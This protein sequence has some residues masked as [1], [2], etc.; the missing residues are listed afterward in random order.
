MRYSDEKKARILKE[1]REGTDPVSAVAG[2]NGVAAS[3][4]VRWDAQAV[5]SEG[6]ARADESP[7]AR[8]SRELAELLQRL[9]R[10]ERLGETERLVA[11]HNQHVSFTSRIVEWLA[12]AL[13]FFIGL[14]VSLLWWEFYTLRRPVSSYIISFMLALLLF[15]LLF[16]I[17]QSLV[18]RLRGFKG[19]GFVSAIVELFSAEEILAQDTTG[20]LLRPSIR[21]VSARNR[22]RRFRRNLRRAETLLMRRTVLGRSFQTIGARE[23]ELA[24]RRRIAATIGYVETLIEYEGLLAYDRARQLLR[25]V[26]ILTLIRDWSLT[27]LPSLPEVPSRYQ[28]RLRQLVLRI[29]APV[30]VLGTLASAFALIGIMNL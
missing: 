22:R 28:S 25:Q 21:Q 6:L 5:D 4:L 29:W 14:T 3:T 20:N 26:A 23:W 13:G 2:R 19:G 17:G 9:Q 8:L 15:W 16:T 12:A 1:F 10:P 27:D 30:P 18:F 11:G 24:N 7:E